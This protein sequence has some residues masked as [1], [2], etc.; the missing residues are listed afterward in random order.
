MNQKEKEI[1][2]R[3]EKGHAEKGKKQ[4]VIENERKRI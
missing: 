4:R 1:E 2:L 3:R